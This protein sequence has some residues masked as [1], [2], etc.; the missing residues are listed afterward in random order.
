MLPAKLVKSVLRGWRSR[1]GTTMLVKIDDWLHWVIGRS[2][3]LGQRKF[4]RLRCCRLDG[5]RRNVRM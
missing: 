2:T 3:Y 4:I 5:G 1:I